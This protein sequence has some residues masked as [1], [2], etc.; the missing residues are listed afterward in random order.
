MAYKRACSGA[1]AVQGLL[2]YANGQKLSGFGDPNANEMTPAWRSS[3][4]RSGKTD[5]CGRSVSR[6]PSQQP[7]VPTARDCPNAAQG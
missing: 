5:G 3:H 1:E 2:P 4:E 6:G 7:V